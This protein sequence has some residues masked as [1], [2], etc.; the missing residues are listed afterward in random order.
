MDTLKFKTEEEK[1]FEKDLE[2]IDKQVRDMVNDK[3]EEMSFEVKA[4]WE[5]DHFPEV[6]DVQVII[7]KTIESYRI[8]KK[9]GK[10]KEA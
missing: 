6:D 1:E 8:F 5:N 3:L 4:G 2:R 9:A 10:P 7:D